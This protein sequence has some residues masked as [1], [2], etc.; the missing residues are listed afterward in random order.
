MMKN[1]TRKPKMI[2][3]SGRTRKISIWPPISGRSAMAPAAAAPMRDCAQAVPMA[4]DATAS[5]AARPSRP[6]ASVRVLPPST[7][8]SAANAAGPPSSKTMASRANTN[9]TFFNLVTS[10]FLERAVRIA[11]LV[12]ILHLR[13]ELNPIE[14]GGL[15]EVAGQGEDEEHHLDRDADERAHPH[16]AHHTAQLIGHVG[17]D[18]RGQPDPKQPGV[19]KHVAHP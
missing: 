14:T 16:R 12:V 19:G 8:A 11:G 6:W 9:R 5:A 10:C 1:A 2:S 17:Q 3:V 15:D 13:E 18:R 4:P 7:C